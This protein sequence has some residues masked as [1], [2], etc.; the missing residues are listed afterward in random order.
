MRDPDD[1]LWARAETR[2]GTVLREKYR[3]ER[4][5]GIGGMASVYAATH[6]NGRR[7]ALKLLHPELSIRADLRQR[8][9]REAQAAN[10]VK[11]PGV[12][13]VIDDDVADDGAAFLVM[14]LLEGQS[15]EEL[16]EAN[17]R[18]LPPKTVLALAFDLCEV[19]A[20]AHEAG[21]VHRDLKPAN[22]FVTREGALK[23]LDFGIARV[24]DEAGP[25]ATQTGSVLGTPAFMAPEQASGLVSELGPLTDIWAVGA[26]MFTLLSGRAVHDGQSGQHI[27]FLAATRPAP[28]L[29]S[30]S[31]EAPPEVVGIV[32]RALALQKAER[33]ASA[34]AMRTAVGEAMTRLTEHVTT[35]EATLARG[36]LSDTMLAVAGVKAIVERSSTLQSPR[37]GAALLGGT[38]GQPVSTTAATE[39]GCATPRAPAW[40][41]GS[42]A[43]RRWFLWGGNGP[44]EPLSDEAPT[45][46]RFSPKVGALGAVV[47]VASVA[48]TALGV[49]TLATPYAEPVR[50]T[51]P[52]APSEGG[53]EPAPSLAAPPEPAITSEVI[54]PPVAA[55]AAA[56]E[57]PR[58]AVPVNKQGQK[59]PVTRPRSGLTGPMTT[60]TAARGPIATCTPPFTIVDG[61]QVH[62]AWC[63]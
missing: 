61:I 24:R 33:W 38:T 47:V 5:I 40:K 11:H 17:G 52:V 10:A 54:P 29:A 50:S 22:L 18:R 32:D 13:A 36:S 42:V 62:K 27:V 28:S 9:L 4:V 30:V 6:R 57:A 25:R 19:L 51:P 23:V 49:S 44:A 16:W 3:I 15:V 53:E 26:T 12:V 56:S 21:V 34:A 37:N 31:P 1:E 46:R 8:F 63:Q 60:A 45:R 48:L 35:D 59:A 58:A 43:I 7:V 55:H 2:V 20:V 39:I 41:R 14:E